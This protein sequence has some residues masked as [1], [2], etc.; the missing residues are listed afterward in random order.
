LKF[1]ISRSTIQ[2][3]TLKLSKSFRGFSSPNNIFK[4]KQIERKVQ[5]FSAIYENIEYKL[6]LQLIEG[7]VTCTED[8]NTKSVEAQ[9]LRI[10]GKKFPSQSKIRLLLEISDNSDTLP[11]RE[12]LFSE[13]TPYPKKG[14]VRFLIFLIFQDVFLLDFL[15]IKRVALEFI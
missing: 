6:L 4:L 7:T 10:L 1:S 2:T 15:H 12:K 11:M 8:K 3:E 14:N 9:M 13:L 5:E